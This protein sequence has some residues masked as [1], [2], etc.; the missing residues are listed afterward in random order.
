MSAGLRKVVALQRFP[1]KAMGVEALESVD[2]GATGLLGDREWAVYDAAGKL[3]TGKHSRRFRRMD[4]V[5][6]A[7]ARRDGDHRSMCHRAR[8]P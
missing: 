4:P 5:F 7:S 2:V 6:T 1:V 8:Y 3:A